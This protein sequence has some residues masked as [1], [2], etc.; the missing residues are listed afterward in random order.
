MPTRKSQVSDLS[1]FWF[2][3]RV[4]V[5]VVVVVYSVTIYASH[6]ARTMEN[7]IM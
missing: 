6:W 2:L 4:V 5:V 7:H 3:L 1:S